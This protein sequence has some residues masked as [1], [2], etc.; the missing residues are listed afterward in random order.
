MSLGAPFRVLLVD[1]DQ[2]DRMA[3]RR[4]LLAIAPRVNIVEAES[5]ASGM[6]SINA[7]PADCLILDYHLP[8]GLGLDLLLHV[9]A[10]NKTLPVIMLT[11]IGDA[12][13]AVELMKAGASGVTEPPP[14]AVS[15]ANLIKLKLFA[16]VLKTVNVPLMA[17]APAPVMVTV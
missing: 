13:T 10:A 12:Q 3:V 1:D 5:V 4:A 8:D 11:A 2:L 17:G 15:A 7:V 9:R 16:V 14:P 6:Q